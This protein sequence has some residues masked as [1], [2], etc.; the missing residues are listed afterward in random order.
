MSTPKPPSPSNHAN[1]A[2]REE[3]L[4]ALTDAVRTLVRVVT[5]NT[6]DRAWTE[7]AA[8]D[9]ASLAER[10]SEGLPDEAPPRYG[11]LRAPETSEQLFPYDPV[12]GPYNPLALPVEVDWEPPKAV[13]RAVF[14][15]PYEG[16]PG[17]VHG[18]VIAAVF[19]QVFNVANIFS[20]Q[21]GPT[22]N[23]SLRYRRPTPLDRPLRFE[24]WVEGVEGRRL[25]SRG[26]LLCADEVTVEAEGLFIVTDAS[27]ILDGLAENRSR[28]R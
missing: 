5:T 6:G 1:I 9:V 17:C 8:R 12:L 15:T 7:A 23:L 14:D 24:A 4:R 13:G 10:L 18:A 25:T 11:A 2:G 21:A 28:V 22:A 16:P 3:P 20:G 19:D 26:A 27:R